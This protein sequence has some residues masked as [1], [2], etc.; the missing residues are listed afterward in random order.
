MTTIVRRSS[1]LAA[2]CFL[3]STAAFAQTAAP[4]SSPTPDAETRPAT[5]TFF[6]DTGIW[7]VPT[8]EVLGN[9]KWSGTAYRRGT[10]WIQGYTNVADFAG[11]FAYGEGPRRDLLI[12][13]RRHADRSRHP[14]AVRQRSGVRRHHRS[15]PAGEQPMDRRQPRRS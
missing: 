14:P 6:G 8:A 9:G 3:L 12:V 11:T 5:T 7:Y 15:L 10:N 2:A 4:A 13:P 1:I